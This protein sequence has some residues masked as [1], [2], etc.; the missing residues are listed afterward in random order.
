MLLEAEAFICTE[1]KQKMS[2]Y[3]YGVNTFAHTGHTILN[4]LRWKLF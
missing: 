1:V 3:I 4:F 2:L